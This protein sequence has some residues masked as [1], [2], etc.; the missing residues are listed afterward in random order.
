[1]PALL[2][3]A[4]IHDTI[5]SG[6]PARVA[7]LIQKDSGLLKQKN[8]DGD[9]PLHLAAKQGD[10]GMIELLL[11]AGADVNARGARGWTPLHYAGASDSKEACLALLNKG[12]DRSAPNEASQKPE[13]TAKVFTKYVIKEYNPQMA[14]ADKLFAA[15]ETGE[16]ETVR[17]L[18]AASP[19]ILRAQDGR[20]STALVLAAGTNK[21]EL[22]QLLLE[23]EPAAKEHAG[24]RYKALTAA[25]KGGYLE[26]VS[27]LLKHGA[28]VNPPHSSAVQ[29]STPLSAA[30]F[31]V[32]PTAA[33]AQ[34]LSAML[35]G[36]NSL[37]AGS[38]DRAS[39]REMAGNL[40]SRKPDVFGDSI[41]E[42]V[43]RWFKAAPEPV[44]EAKRAI[45]R[46]LLEA[47]ADPKKDDSV[48][49]SASTSGETEMV[50][51]LLERGA[52]PNAEQKGAA[53]GTAISYAV[54]VNAPLPLIQQ[55]LAAGADP[56]RVA[57]P[58]SSLG[59]SALSI[60][61]QFKNKDAIDAILG[62]LKPGKLPEARHFE[63]FESLL[64]GD[65]AC[66]RRALDGGFKVNARGAAGWT[67]LNRAVQMA[68][69]EVASLLLDA[70]ADVKSR[71]PAGY[72]PLHTAA[73][74]G[75][76]EQITLLLKHGAD[77]E[78]R[79]HKDGTAVMVAC[80]PDG[81]EEAVAAL[82]KAGA[83]IDAHDEEGYTALWHAAM[84]GR[85]RIVRR[86]LESG[87]D[88]NHTD[89][90]GYS[91][92]GTA[93]AGPVDS[94]LAPAEGG[95]QKRSRSNLGSKEDYVESAKLLIKHGAKVDGTGEGS[96]YLP[97]Y[98]AL[99]GGFKEMAD[100]LLEN[101]AKVDLVGKDRRTPIQGAVLGCI[102][103]LLERVIALG[104]KPD[105]LVNDDESTVL[106]AA[107][108]TNK[109]LMAEIL[110]KH[111]ARVNAK[112]ITGVT[113]LLNAV[114]RNDAETVRILLKYGARPD[115]AALDGMTPRALAAKINRSEILSMLKTAK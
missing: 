18:I 50:R 111:G 28:A 9:Q 98:L 81:T 106:H 16:A 59:A 30:A 105:T 25:A 74:R 103:E 67:P 14:G 39:L 102:P 47:G 114:S 61:V 100:L 15:I 108:A 51:L 48:L 91:V 34:A 54:A 113:P 112:S 70:G 94:K 92:L 101:G 109:P 12:A 26:V 89:R 22:V 42:T 63:V 71:D 62:S 1:M 86:L 104:A 68:N 19:K 80:S 97:L 57:N 2:P 20:G 23:A 24:E 76:A 4:E 10:A 40:K 11:N 90:Q 78:A 115:I 45:L 107:A 17:A 60:A 53:S 95:F 49:V 56:L 55:L 27:L 41:Q 7:A 21:P 35:A 58:D 87:A 37:P 85:Q 75:R 83:K 44:R 66:V 64:R 73:E 69:P 79:T 36:T 88:P 96:I 29:D 43:A 5:Q 72:T 52:N 33:G 31:T 65:P 82:V 8:A 84:L 46:L 99:S 38:Q 32:E 13:Q 93:A 110:L 6:D 3:A 77:L